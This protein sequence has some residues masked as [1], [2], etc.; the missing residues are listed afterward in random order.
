MQTGRVEWVTPDIRRILAPNPS[1]MTGP[2]TNTYILGQGKGVVVVDPGPADPQH[3]DAVLAALGA[4]TVAAIVVT[5]AHKDHSA[6]APLLS[7]RAAAPILAFGDARSGRSAVMQRLAAEGLVGGGEGVD[8]GFR[9]DRLLTDGDVLDSG[10]KGLRVI[11]T[12]G[13]MGG[14]IC[15]GFGDVLLSGDHAMSW[16]SSL[17]SPPDGDMADYMASLARLASEQW[18]L[19]LPGHGAAVQDPAA[20]LHA[21]I[22]HRKER[23]AE[24]LRVLHSGPSDPLR[25]TA[26]IY[27]DTPT[28]LRPAAQR[29]I[30]AHLIDL[31]ER[32]VITYND[33]P[34]PQT[35]FTRSDIA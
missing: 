11:H 6:A 15:L 32:K 7:A 31:S 27:H 23:E 22:R 20:R 18:S 13:H 33:P 10:G 12:P 4:E 24:V 16:A 9:P 21:L 2:G 34:G 25:L 28:A 14:H 35:I 1:P 17:I 26:Q 19:M 8:D 30:L 3:I 29:N 5:H